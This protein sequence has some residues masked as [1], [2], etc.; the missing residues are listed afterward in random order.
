MAPHRSVGRDEWVC[1]HGNRGRLCRGLLARW[2]FVVGKGAEYAGG[3]L[4][5]IAVWMVPLAI[6]GFE[7]ASGLWP[8]GNPGGYNDY[9]VFVK[10][11]WALMEVG[12]VVAGALAIWQRPFPF[13]T[14]PIA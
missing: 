7:R 13:L 1:R 4:F 8:Q 11:S 5:T 9:Y 10:G 6:H 14:F 12:T 3:L 2:R